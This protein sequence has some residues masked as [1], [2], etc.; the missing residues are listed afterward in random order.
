[1]SIHIS[2][3]VNCDGQFLP[4][5]RAEGTGI[6]YGTRS[7]GSGVTDL[8][9]CWWWDAEG[10]RTPRE[11]RQVARRR[12]WTRKKVGGELFDLCPAC[13]KTVRGSA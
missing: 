5:G 9:S 6:N 8:D 10:S 13:A 1:M 4:T 2:H 11:A 12:G 7:S 3:T